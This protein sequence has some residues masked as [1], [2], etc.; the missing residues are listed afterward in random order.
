[1]SCFQCNKKRI[2]DY[3]NIW[4]YLR[5]LYNTT[6]FGDTTNRYHIEHHYM[7]CV[8]IIIHACRL[9][10]ILVYLCII[11]HAADTC[12]LVHTSTSSLNYDHNWVGYGGGMVGYGSSIVCNHFYYYSFMICR[13]V[14][15]KLIQNELFL[16]VPILIIPFLMVVIQSLNEISIVNNIVN[17]SSVGH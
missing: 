10:L 1:M 4:G 17:T 8:L 12:I 5:D 2:V 15:N 16:L 3:P 13:V 7:V 9:Q 6:G 14:M 11:I